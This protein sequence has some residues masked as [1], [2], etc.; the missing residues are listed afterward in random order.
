MWAPV[1]TACGLSSFGSWGLEL[2]LSS[3]GAQAL[4]LRGMWDLLGPGIELASP[5]LAGRLFT[6]ESPAKP[7][8]FF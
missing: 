2:G 5:A 7:M 4:L 8:I 6:T 3:C 1:V